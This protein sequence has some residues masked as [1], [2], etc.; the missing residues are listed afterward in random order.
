MAITHIYLITLSCKYLNRCLNL[1]ATDFS[2][3]VENQKLTAIN[4]EE[5]SLGH[6]YAKQ[7]LK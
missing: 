3:A 1:S 6:K 4:V 2:F 5:M 7:S